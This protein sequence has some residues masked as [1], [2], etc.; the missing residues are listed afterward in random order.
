MSVSH[1]NFKDYTLTISYNDECT[2]NTISTT[3]QIV[4]DVNMSLS[5]DKSTYTIGETIR[6]TGTPT[7]IPDGWGNADIY[8]FYGSPRESDFLH[9]GNDIK[10]D[11]L[12]LNYSFDSTDLINPGTYEVEVQVFNDNEILTFELK[13][14]TKDKG[15]SE[16]KETIIIPDTDDD[17]ILDDV[18][19]CITQKE[20]FN[21]Y[22]DSDGCPDEEFPYPILYLAV[23]VGLTIPV[24]L[25]IFTK[26]KKTEIRKTT[27]FS[28]ID[29]SSSTSESEDQD[30][31][32]DD[33]KLK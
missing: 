17:G 30:Y 14:E 29:Q 1:W 6:I 3:A 23:A 24:I 13:D 21:N 4:D 10:F 8:V 31:V 19:Q 5:T 15:E 22:Q 12:G 18:D 2:G 25:F 16:T 28:Q 27:S 33:S 9:F 20:N 7:R 32:L 26:R 11:S